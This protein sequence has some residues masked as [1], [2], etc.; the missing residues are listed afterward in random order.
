MS[1]EDKRAR[2]AALKATLQEKTA[3]NPVA[4]RTSGQAAAVASLSRAEVKVKVLGVPRKAERGAVYFD[5]YVVDIEDSSGEGAMRIPS[6]SVPDDSAFAYTPLTDEK[7]D[8]PMKYDASYNK[9]DERKP[10]QMA[11]FGVTTVK[12]TGAPTGPVDWATSQ[13]L[14]PGKEISMSGAA[15]TTAFKQG[16]VLAGGY[17]DACA[18]TNGDSFTHL[19]M[20]MSKEAFKLVAGNQDLALRNMMLGMDTGGFTNAWKNTDATNKTKLF[21]VTALDNERKTMFSANG[22]L[23]KGMELISGEG[24]QK[25]KNSIL[26]FMKEFK[27]SAAFNN[28]GLGMGFTHASN[29]PSILMPV[30]GLGL[31]IGLEDMV[32]GEDSS[33]YKEGVRARAPLLFEGVLG[34]PDG[35][36]FFGSSFKQ[37]TQRASGGP[38]VSLPIIAFA[39]AKDSEPKEMVRMSS[40][41]VMKMSLTA[42]PAHIGSKVMETIKRITSSIL[43]LVNM[44]VSFETDRNNMYTNPKAAETFD[45]RFS[46]IDFRSA[47]LKYGIELDVEGAL[48]HMEN[49]SI[50]MEDA[51]VAS[52]FTTQ[53]KTF[54]AAGFTLLNE[55]ADA[56]SPDWLEKQKAQM[57]KILTFSNRKAKSSIA[58]YTIH[59]S[60]FRDHK[61]SLKSM[62][63]MDLVERVA[64]LGD[65]WPIF[66][67]FKLDKISEPA[68]TSSEPALKKQKKG[69]EA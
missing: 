30:Y 37:G 54:L 69:A 45:C 26:E 47:L 67:V 60:G 65:I 33:F 16:T 44:T 24:D 43:P 28:E 52:T 13:A 35:K 1:S 46:A 15:M 40:P 23:T 63:D 34:E 22:P 5:G 11:E 36:Q 58:M 27:S 32:P 29:G 9:T 38:W 51:D 41:V 17:K 4:S 68:E 25:W 50:S 2:I 42:M 6:L 39:K 66:A 31:D 12:V 14:F 10:L 18:T 49:K 64:H 19:D 61:E 8:Y 21:A 7:G 59:P 57:D 53:P 55:N 62:K 56:R 3:N 48:C 20:E